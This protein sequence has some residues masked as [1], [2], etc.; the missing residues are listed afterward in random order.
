[1]EFLVIEGNIGAGKTTLS[2]KI[3]ER[4]NARL[5]LERFE[6]NPFLPRFYTDPARFAFP[7]ELSFLADRYH[8]LKKDL[9]SKDLFQP[10][11]ISDYYFMK[12][13]IFARQTLAD[14]EYML[15]R[16]LFDII[17]GHLPRPDLYVYLHVSTHSLLKRIQQ[18]GRSYE[19]D[20][21]SEYLERIHQGYLDFFKQ[22]NELPVLVLH[23]ENL[24]YLDNEKDFKRV[25]EIIFDQKYERGTTT[26]IP[27]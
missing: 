21:Q 8:Q 23:A 6:E 10:M 15:Y 7:V 17:Y 19:Q 9:A 12:S 2:R 13:L 14:D 4:Y 20:I 18:R 25:C 27:E 16:Q 22:Q 24:N 1:M 3:A 5:I 11:V 26:L